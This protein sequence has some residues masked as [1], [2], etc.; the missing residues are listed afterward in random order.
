ML[1]YPQ[2]AD[3]D[4]DLANDFNITPEAASRLRRII[5]L[6]ES[7]RSTLIFVQGRGQ[8]ESLG[9]NLRRINPYIE[10]H[11]GSLSKEQRHL[12]EDGFKKGELKGIV[13]TSTLQLGIDIGNV[14]LC[15]QYLSPRRVS[16]LIQ[17]VGR[18][19]HAI[20]KRSEGVVISAYGEDAL[21][22]LIL[23]EM[24]AQGE[25]EEIDLHVKPLD[26]LAHQIVGMALEE[27]PITIEEAFQVITRAT[28]FSN[29]GWEELL[30]VADFLKNQ[31][32]VSLKG[33]MLMETK[34]SRKYYYENL[35]MMNDERRYPFV[36]LVSDRI[37]G[38][39]GDEFWTL[40]A[41]LGFNVIMKGIV[42]RIIQIDD[43]RGVL[44]APPSDD[45]LGALPGWDGELMPVA[46]EIA[47]KVGDIRERIWRKMGSSDDKILEDL[48]DSIE[49][50]GDVFKVIGKEIEAH[51]RAGFPIPTKK[52]ILLEAYEKYLIIHGCF[53]DKLATT[54]GCV[55]DSILSEHD[56]IYSWWNDPYR[57][58]IETTRTLDRFDLD[59]IEKWFFNL[60]DD[61]LEKRLLDFMESRFP[62]GYKMKFIAERF[63]ALKKGKT[64]NSEIMKNLY[65]RFKRTPIYKETLREVHQEKLDLDSAEKLMEEISSGEVKIVK[66]LAKTPSPLAM[67]I[68][69]AHLELSELAIPAYVIENQLDKM[70]KSIESRN[71]QL[72][73]INCGDWSV[74]SKLRLISDKPLCG[75]CGSG[76]L[77]ML[78]PHANPTDFLEIVKKYQSNEELSE[79]MMRLLTYGRKTAGLI[80]LY[81]KKAVIA[82]SVH[83]VGPITAFKILSRMHRREKEFYSELLKAKI[84]YLKTRPFWRD[85][86]KKMGL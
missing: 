2:V 39:V 71:V 51:V 15:I 65:N 40:R 48:A 69:K 17:R 21:E 6:V 13:C 7:H 80:L 12:T 67:N 63:G 83:G 73:C 1:E 22:S 24:A 41:R 78:N 9:Y 47:E 75:K 32:L 5:T 66:V 37:I 76:L 11:H 86:K 45:P 29:T 25:L 53:G 61:E 18:S 68:L 70:K 59:N 23:L 19:G 85:D 57:I 54:L 50:D 62:F 16:T 64:L 60:E 27:D 3:E 35:G 72:C 77:A 44:Y 42:W 38:T 20:S 49:I 31:G 82:L 79:E 36:D 10:V 55:F 52:R 14:D 84:Q 4:Y 43:E 74:K 56:L 81:G 28:P 8:A 33:D 34:K 58:L 46:K 26:V 30:E